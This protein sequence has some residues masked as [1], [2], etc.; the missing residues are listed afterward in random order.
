MHPLLA[1][2]RFTHA[3]ISYDVLSPP[4]SNSVLDRSTRSSVPSH[5]LS[6]PATDPPTFGKLILQSDKFPLGDRRPVAVQSCFEV[7]HCWLS[8]QEG[9]T[10]D[11]S[12]RVQRRSSDACAAN[13]PGGMGFDGQR[14]P[15][16][17]AR[18][19]TPTRSGARKWAADGTVAC[20]GSISWERRLGSLASRSRRPA[21]TRP[22]SR[23]CVSGRR[24]L[25]LFFLPPIWG[26]I[27]S[28]LCGCCAIQR[29][30]KHLNHALASGCFAEDIHW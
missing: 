21:L 24:E 18:R 2:T 27:L 1:S 12:R 16:P 3:P 29:H 10:G 19:R 25:F 4:S 17:N 9:R 13:D 28:C 5:T 26:H 11:E 30:L 20:A 7:L 22:V 15:G 6:Q 23:N 14:K 8:A